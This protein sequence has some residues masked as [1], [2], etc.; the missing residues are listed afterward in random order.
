M[1]N[2]TYVEDVTTRRIYVT[3]TDDQ[4]IL[5][6]LQRV[7]TPAESPLLPPRLQIRADISSKEKSLSCDHHS[8][9]RYKYVYL[10]NTK[11]FIDYKVFY[12]K[13]MAHI[14]CIDDERFKEKSINLMR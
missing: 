2:W 4:V 12:M 8:K 5:W 14:Y 6:E 10:C 3:R 1:E 7:L 9:N 13:G 11:Y